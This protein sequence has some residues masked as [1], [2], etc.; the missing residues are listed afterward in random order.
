MTIT[1]TVSFADG[2]RVTKTEIDIH[3]EHTVMCSRIINSKLLH[4]LITSDEK[5][6]TAG[7]LGNLTKVSDELFEVLANS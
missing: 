6:I 7:M 1:N 5:P 3:N 2:A 4:Y